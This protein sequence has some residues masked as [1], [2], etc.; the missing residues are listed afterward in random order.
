MACLARVSWFTR[1]TPDLPALDGT[2][3]FIEVTVV[4]ASTAID[5]K[6]LLEKEDG[7]F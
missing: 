7:A 1:S 5:L 2:I 3:P 4:V 6:C